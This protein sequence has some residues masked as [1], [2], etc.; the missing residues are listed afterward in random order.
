MA[1]K[2]LNTYHVSFV[3]EVFTSIEIK[4]ESLEDALAR[5]K[6]FHVTDVVEIPGEHI[7][8]TLKLTGVYQ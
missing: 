3:V 8:S 2:K 5:A 6:E 1:I 7:D 4:A